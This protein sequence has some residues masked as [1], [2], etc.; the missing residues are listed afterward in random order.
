MFNAVCLG[1]IRTSSGIESTGGIARR[2]FYSLFLLI[3]FHTASVMF[4]S[5]IKIG[6]GMILNHIL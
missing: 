4:T 2:S 5:S 1:R 6:K 3:N